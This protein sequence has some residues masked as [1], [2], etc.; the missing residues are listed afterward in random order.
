MMA[1]PSSRRGSTA[2]CSSYDLLPRELIDLA[3]RIAEFGKHIV[4]VRA[5]L[6]RRHARPWIAAR[7]PETRTHD[8]NRAADAGGL[9]EISQQLALDN[10]RVV[11]NSRDVK[12]LA[13]RHAMLVEDDGPIARGPAGKRRLDLGLE[14][15][16]MALAILPP[17]E[18]WIG[19]EVLAPDEAAEGFELLLLVGR[20]VEQA[21]SGAQRSG[22]AR[23][24]VLVAHRPRPHTRNQPVRDHPAH[25]DQS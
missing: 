22:G 5:Q 7:K 21:L 10:L 11:E 17:G 25:G 12:H 6:W 16:A 20:N 23:G 14:L 8:L 3:L 15:P 9:D 2:T 18:A 19:D 13:S 24:H 4:G 1:V